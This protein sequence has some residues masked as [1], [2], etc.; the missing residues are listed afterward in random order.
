MPDFMNTFCILINFYFVRYLNFL[1][2]DRYEHAGKIQKKSIYTSHTH[3]YILTKK[4]T[5]SSTFFS[6]YTKK[7]INE[8]SGERIVC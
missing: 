4:E 3:N 5:Q 8:V 6:I 7:L 2:T 1:H